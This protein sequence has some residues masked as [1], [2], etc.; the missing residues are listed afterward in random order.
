MPY[1]LN[2]RFSR[3]NAWERFLLWLLPGRRRAHEERL[4]AGIRFVVEHPEIPVV[5]D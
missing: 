3:L 1:R 4:K 2:P 5:I